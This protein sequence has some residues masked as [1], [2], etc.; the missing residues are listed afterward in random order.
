MTK[1]LRRIVFF[2]FV[3]VFFIGAPKIVFYALGYSY[4]HGSESGLVKSGLVYLSTTPPGATVYVGGRRYRDATPAIIRDLLPGNYPIR[5]VL[6]DYEAWAQTVPVEPAKS[7]VLGK[8]LLHPKKP[9]WSMRLSDQYE[10]IVLVPD[11][12][13]FLLKKKNQADAVQIYD[14]KEKKAK[15]FE[16]DPAKVQSFFKAKRSVDDTIF[17][18]DENGKFSSGRG[19]EVIVKQSVLGFLYDKKNHKTVIWTKNAIGLVEKIKPKKELGVLQG[20]WSVQWVFKQGQRIS[21]AFWA[22]DG[23]CILFQDQSKVLMLEL[24]TFGAPATYELLETKY[25]SHIFYSDE[26][27]EV[28]YLDKKSGNLMSLEVIPKWKVLEIPFTLLQEKEKEAKVAR[29]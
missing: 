21:Q 14:W 13:Y 18:L 10:D 4:R 29:V 8:I 20:S 15:P 16:D 17:L 26:S 23:A 28:F 5:L 9:D 22:H 19:G 1:I 3:A 12:K 24:E 25:Q 7:S 2:F 27:G 11:T 6:K